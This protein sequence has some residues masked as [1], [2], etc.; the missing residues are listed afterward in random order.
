MNSDI[1]SVAPLCSDGSPIGEVRRYYVGNHPVFLAHTKDWGDLGPFVAIED[2]IDTI[3]GFINGTSLTL[4]NS[5][6]C[7]SLEQDPNILTVNP[8]DLILDPKTFQ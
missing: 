1:F 5:Q 4:E 6:D 2:L 8:A 3:D 7:D